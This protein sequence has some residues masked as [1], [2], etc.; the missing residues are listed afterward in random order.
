MRTLS[1][2]ST[3]RW[4][5]LSR[6]AYAHCHAESRQQGGAVVTQHMGLEL[7]ELQDWLESVHNKLAAPGRKGPSLQHC[8]AA[9]L[10]LGLAQQSQ[11]FLQQVSAKHVMLV[12]AAHT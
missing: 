7:Y 2:S 5:S 11:E 1:C 4:N 6:R 10:M 8:C 3:M 12:Q 9:P